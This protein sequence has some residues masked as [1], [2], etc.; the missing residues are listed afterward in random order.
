[1]F[2]PPVWTPLDLVAAGLAFA[3]SRQRREVVGP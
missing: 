1:M 3:A 2:I